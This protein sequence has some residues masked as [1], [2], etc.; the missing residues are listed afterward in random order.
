MSSDL[1]YGS[2][3]N[4]HWFAPGEPA[5]APD[6]GA[7]Q[8]GWGVFESIAWRAGR[9]ELVA[10]HLARLE[11]DARAVDLAWPPHFDPRAALEE[12]VRRLPAS[13]AMVRA[14]Y[15]RAA[16]GSSASLAIT[17]RALPV[18]PASGAVLALG[19]H[20]RSPT[21]PFAQVKCTSRLVYALERERAHARGAW[22]ALVLTTD[23]D[24][25]ETSIANVWAW[26][27][28]RWH[29]PPRAR[30]CLPGVVRELLLED[31]GPQGGSVERLE[32]DALARAREI[33]VTN[34]SVG[35]LPVASVLGIAE[36]LPGERGVAVR[37]LRGRW[38]RLVEGERTPSNA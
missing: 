21:D 37:E 6:D 4:G 24:V 19:D 8:Y 17:A 9:L 29:T 15:S 10:R 7:F 18:A 16:H 34:S 1:Q 33:A 28:G 31:L 5:I 38:L 23:G 30:G 26:I 20:R 27:D 2:W 32:L 3:V 25:C 13:D 35:V 36:S 12:F 22:D 14:T 11:R